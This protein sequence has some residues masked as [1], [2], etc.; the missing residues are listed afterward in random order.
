MAHGGPPQRPPGPVVSHVMPGAAPSSPFAVAKANAIRAQAFA[1]QK[2]PLQA[3]GSWLL[4]KNG[5]GGVVQDAVAPTKAFIKRPGVSTGIQ[6]LASLPLGRPRSVAEA[7]SPVLYH[8]TSHEN[9]A[10]IRARGYIEP[11]DMR[12]E[13]QK[14]AWLSATPDHPLHNFGPAVIPVPRANLPASAIRSRIGPE[15]YASPERVPIHAAVRP[16]AQLH[17]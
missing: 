16:A 12:G 5:L 17:S 6:A 1:A 4:G 9:A 2:S 14:F 15:A 11:N 8:R 13:G 10:Q 7:E 3:F